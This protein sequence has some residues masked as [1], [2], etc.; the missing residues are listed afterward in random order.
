MKKSILSSGLLIALLIAPA[1]RSFS[2]SEDKLKEKIEKIN[3]KFAEAFIAGDH[4]MHLDYYVDDAISLPS[5]QSMLKG[6]E[7]I[8]AS[9]KEAQNSPMKVTAFELHIKKIE[10][11]GDLIIEIGK[12]SMSF[13]MPEMPEPGSD[14]G[15]Y[16]TVWEKQSDGSLKIKYET[17]NTD[18]NPW[19]Q[20]EKSHEM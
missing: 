19:A 13:T 12:Y 20:M 11:C 3:A 4:E 18:T 7:A 10:V 15:K 2:Q 6:I 5:Y 16:L 8:T 17:W 9:A 1:L 14:N